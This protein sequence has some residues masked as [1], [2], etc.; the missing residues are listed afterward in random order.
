MIPSSTTQKIVFTGNNNE[1]FSISK[2]DAVIIITV[3]DLTKKMQLALESEEYEEISKEIGTHISKINK[4]YDKN[5]KAI[6]NSKDLLSI[7]VEFHKLAEKINEERK[8]KFSFSLSKPLSRGKSLKEEV[9]EISDKTHEEKDWNLL[10]ESKN[11][12]TYRT[13][14]NSSAMSQYLPKI[15]KFLCC[16]PCMNNSNKNKYDLN[17]NKYSETQNG[18]HE[19]E[20]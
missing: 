6:A 1:E 15:F 3:Q 17:Q 5:I 2:E 4:W 19:A 9:D 14:H 13:K 12:F 11:D 8:Y 10:K 16:L 20:L 7:F 18:Y